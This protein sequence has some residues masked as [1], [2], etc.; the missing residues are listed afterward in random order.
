MIAAA[1]LYVQKNQYTQYNIQTKPATRYYMYNVHCT[2]E[3]TIP[4][5]SRNEKKSNRNDRQRISIDDE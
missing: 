3:F 5:R 4:N 1:M 2:F